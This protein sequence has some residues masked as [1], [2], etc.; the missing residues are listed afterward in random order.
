MSPRGSCWPSERRTRAKGAAACWRRPETVFGK[1]GQPYKIKDVSGAWAALQN[2]GCPWF[3]LH[4]QWL[5][6]DAALC[7]LLLPSCFV[8][9]VTAESPGH[10]VSLPRHFSCSFVCI[11]IAP[12]PHP[13]SVYFLLQAALL[14]IVGTA[15]GAAFVYC[16]SLCSRFFVPRCD[17]CSNTSSGTLW[18]PLLHLLRL[19]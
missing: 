17:R 18:L 15:T 3:L 1:R 6:R 10:E 19:A 16:C 5:P 7:T 13:A 8:L 9:R 4:K 11:S 14:Y 12:P 2:K